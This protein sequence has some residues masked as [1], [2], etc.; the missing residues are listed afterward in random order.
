MQWPQGLK[1]DWG[2]NKEENTGIAREK[3]I[4]KKTRYALGLKTLLGLLLRQEGFL[5]AAASIL[6]S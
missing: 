4:A 3:A 6:F 2:Q 1:A 5:Y